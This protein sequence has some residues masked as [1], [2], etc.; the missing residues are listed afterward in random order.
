MKLARFLS[1]IIPNFEV[2]DVKEWLKDGHIDIYLEA[3]EEHKMLCQRCLTPL[4]GYHSRYPV[5]LQHLPI[6]NF[7]TILHL[8]RRKG[9]CPNC[10]KIRSERFDFISAETPHQTEEFSWWL[11]RLCEVTTIKKASDFSNINEMTLWRTDFK[12][13]KRL[14]Q[15]YK[16][17]DVKR[18]SIDEVYAQKYRK[19]FRTK[20]RADCFLTV[21]CD[22]DTRRVVW[23]SDGRSK[24]ALGE[25]FKYYGEDRCKKIQVVVADQFDGYKT[26]TEEYCPSAIFVWDR[27]HLVQSMETAVDETRK[28][29]FHELSWEQ[30]TKKL[31]RGKW[32]YIFLQRA[33]RRTKEDSEHMEEI[34]KRNEKFLKLE[35]IKEKFLTFFECTDELQGEF[36]LSDIESWIKL[37]KFKTLEKWLN[38][39]KSGWSTLRNWFKARVTTSLSEGHNNVIKTLKRRGYGYKN[40]SYFKLKI[41]QTC[42]YLNSKHI[43]MNFQQLQQIC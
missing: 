10:K 30:E 43:P 11:G 38:N 31:A 39:L 32:K 26:A 21:I 40:M 42:G 6:F 14:F 22:L 9:H 36:A 29:I 13:M 5:Q 16:I 8:Q 34:F 15:Y 24:E 19:G 7:K 35:L 27:F 3:T 28:E 17:P 33:N 23:V 25:F 41:L 37:C 18:I 4:S 20:S 1:K 12:R 2:Y